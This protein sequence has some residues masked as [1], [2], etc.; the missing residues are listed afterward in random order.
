MNGDWLFLDLDVIVTGRL[1]VFFE[2]EPEKSFVV[3]QNWT[4]PGKGIGN[5]PVF[6]FRVGKHPYIY[7][8]LVPEFSSILEK[9]NNEQIYISRTVSEM[10][11]WPDEWYALFKTHCVPPMPLRWWKAPTK[12]AS[13]R[14]VAFPGDPNPPDA[15]PGIWPAKNGTREFTSLFYR[16]HGLPV[17][18]VNKRAFVS[19][20]PLGIEQNIHATD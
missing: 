7:D 4:Q 13:A 5:T 6:R 19:F 17:I 1:D 9:Y 8:R 3:M 18:G 10:I 14:V 20:R 16:R 11:F 2:F 15:L 12:S